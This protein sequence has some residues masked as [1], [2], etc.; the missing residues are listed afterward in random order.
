MTTEKIERRDAPPHSTVMPRLGLG[1]HEFG[2]TG[3]KVVDPRAK[4]GDDDREVE[5]PCVVLCYD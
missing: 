4:P 5:A 2:A 1:I 3:K